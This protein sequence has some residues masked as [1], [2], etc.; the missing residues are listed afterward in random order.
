MLLPRFLG[1]G[2]RHSVCADEYV[3]CRCMAR[4]SGS[5]GRWTAGNDEHCYEPLQM[6][7]IYYKRTIIIILLTTITNKAPLILNSIVI[8]RIL[9]K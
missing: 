6:T 4:W 9:Y 7:M 3:Y 5:G 8:T 1:D 2:I